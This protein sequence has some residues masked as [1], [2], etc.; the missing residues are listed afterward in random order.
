MTMDN[1]TGLWPSINLVRT[2]IKF[3]WGLIN[4]RPTPIK[5]GEL[6]PASAP[7]DLLPELVTP[8]LA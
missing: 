8:R 6:P 2:L 4:L 3:I 7:Q 5:A 1:Q